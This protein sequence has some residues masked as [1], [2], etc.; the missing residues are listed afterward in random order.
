MQQGGSR[1]TVY[2]GLIGVTR[3]VVF[4]H[5]ADAYRAGNGFPLCNDLCHG[6]VIGVHRFDD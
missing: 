4:R 6:W 3:H 1:D 5:D 2:S